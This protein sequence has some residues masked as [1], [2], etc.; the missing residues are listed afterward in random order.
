[1][2]NQ[3]AKILEATSVQVVQS[4]TTPNTD[5]ESENDD[6]LYCSNMSKAADLDSWKKK[7]PV[8]FI[9]KHLKIV[10]LS[11]ISNKKDLQ[12]IK[13]VLGRFPVLEMMRVSYHDKL[14]ITEEN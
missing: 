4:P 3:L 7:C 11:G 12:F 10:K 1:M 6:E 5:L 8:D 9:L 2:A 13:F 14:K